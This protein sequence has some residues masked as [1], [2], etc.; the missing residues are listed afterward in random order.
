MTGGSNGNFFY[1]ENI[2]TFVSGVA[3]A[4][5]IG[6][7]NLFP[8]PAT[9]QVTVK[10]W[11]VN[12]LQYIEKV[13]FSAGANTVWDIAKL[14]SKTTSA[15]SGTA[16]ADTINGWDGID[17]IAALGGNDTI[18][19]YGGNDVLDGGDGNDSISAG[20]GND[21]VLGGIGLDTID[22]GTGDDIIDGGDDNDTITDTSGVNTLKGGA[23]NDTITGSGTFGGGTGNDSLTASD[24][25]FGDTYQV[26][27]G[28]R[29]AKINDYD[30]PAATA[31]LGA[32]DDT[33]K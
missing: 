18:N 28:D 23:G 11:D 22:S 4:N 3:V 32:A 1:F 27:E 30:S 16:A 26:N 24:F 6:V 19:A 25:W 5:G 15:Y 10:N 17:S 33:M 14:K 20:D 21:Q 13:Q 2:T 7:F 9:D 8:N 29:Q 12:G 31:H